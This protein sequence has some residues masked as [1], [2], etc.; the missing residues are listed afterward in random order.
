MGNCT[1]RPI[2]KGELNTGKN[3]EEKQTIETKNEQPLSQIIE[4]HVIQEEK[5]PH[6]PDENVALKRDNIPEELLQ[7]PLRDKIMS[8]G[9]YNYD[10]KENP[11]DKIL[12]DLGPYEYS[13]DGSFYQGQY[14]YG[15]RHGHGKLTTRENSFY[16]GIW[17][18]DKFI[19]G[20]WFYQIDKDVWVYEGEVLDGKKSWFW[21]INKK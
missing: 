20:K 13:S 14:K 11:D 18:Y 15:K 12:P 21:N 10:E 5:N 17:S 7:P 9:S 4:N 16:E 3:G 2:E 8:V 19:K 6:E 1:D